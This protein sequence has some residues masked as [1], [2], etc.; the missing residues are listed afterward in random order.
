MGESGGNGE[1]GRFG[2][3]TVGVSDEFE[4]EALSVGVGEADGSLG[5]DGAIRAGTVARLGS[6]DAVTSFGVEAVFSSGAWV[7]DVATEDWD[8]LAG[9]AGGTVSAIGAGYGDGEEGGEDDL[10]KESEI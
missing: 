1:S 7:D 4:L 8:N 9:G 6:Y 2:L 5:F 3:V 10:E